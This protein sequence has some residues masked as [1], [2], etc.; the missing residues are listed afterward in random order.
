VIHLIHPQAHEPISRTKLPE[1]KPPVKAKFGFI[2]V[3]IIQDTVAELDYFTILLFY[4]YHAHMTRT[5]PRIPPISIP[6]SIISLQG[7]SPDY[8]GELISD[9]RP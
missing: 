9:H 7:S 4:Y 5:L 6:Q 8:L 3:L 1:N 2:T